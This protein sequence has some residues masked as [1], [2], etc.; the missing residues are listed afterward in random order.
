M[1]GRKAGIMTHLSRYR[2][3]RVVVH[4]GWAVFPVR[5]IKDDSNRGL[6]DAGLTTFIDEILLIL[7]THLE[8]EEVIRGYMVQ[9]IWRT[10]TD[11]MLVRPRTKQMASRMFDFPEPLRPVMALKEVSHPV[12]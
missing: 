10:R 11:D 12:I 3:L 9:R 2:Y 1:N 8:T 5:I 4:S 7:R 6:G